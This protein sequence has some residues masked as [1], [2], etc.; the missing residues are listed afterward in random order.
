ME[1]LVGRIQERRILEDAMASSGEELI[2]VYG[3]GKTGKTFLIRSIYEK[4]LRFEFTG[5]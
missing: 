2:A 3:R 1:K 5:K 4:Y